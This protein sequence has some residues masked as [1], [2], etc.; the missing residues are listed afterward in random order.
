ME[1]Q[2]IV[3]IPSPE[4][5]TI[6]QAIHGALDKVRW[7]ELINR[8][9]GEVYTCLRK[10]PGGP[11]KYHHAGTCLYLKTTALDRDLYK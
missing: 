2:S 5:E 6:L 3:D 9:L 1:A 4:T 7:A 10:G 8:R 11:A